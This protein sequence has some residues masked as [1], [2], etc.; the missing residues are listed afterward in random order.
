LT[1]LLPEKSRRT[2]RLVAVDQNKVLF[3]FLAAP[4]D[5]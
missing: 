4:P 2:M 3:S 1:A 5:R